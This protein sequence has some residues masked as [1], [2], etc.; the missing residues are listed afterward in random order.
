M[1]PGS[2][3]TV[4]SRALLAPS[5]LPWAMVVGKRPPACCCGLGAASLAAAATGIVRRCPNAGFQPAEIAAA[6]LHGAGLYWYQNPTWTKRTIDAS[7]RIST[8]IAVRDL[9]NDLKLD[10]VVV[11]YNGLA[12]YENMGSAWVP[13][14]I[15]NRVLHDSLHAGLVTDMSRKAPEPKRPLSELIKEH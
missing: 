6:D 3:A 1:G 14:S 7:A 10:V 8:D 13:H 15:S 5:R 12:W 4:T 2:T 11:T 9:N